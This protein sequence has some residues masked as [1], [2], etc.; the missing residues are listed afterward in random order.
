MSC[1]RKIQFNTVY[2]IYEVANFDETVDFQY[3]R[4]EDLQ[5]LQATIDHPFNGTKGAII[6]NELFKKL[7]ENYSIREQL[8]DC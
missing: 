7:D 2:G 4:D 3:Y 5:I 1:Y 6:S 8:G